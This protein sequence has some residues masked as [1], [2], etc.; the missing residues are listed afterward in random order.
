MYFAGAVL[1]LF[2]PSWA[3]T[4]H[5]GA[6]RKEIGSYGGTRKLTISSTTGTTLF[7]ADVKRPDGSCRFYGT[8]YIGT[9]SA[10]QENQVHMNIQIGFPVYSTETFILEG[11]FTGDWYVTAATN[12][13][14]V[15]GRCIDGLVR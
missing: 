3:D 9:T 6:T 11:S 15:E 14:N 1:G 10:T 13:T 7:A 5:E 12:T 8:V 4:G 2:P